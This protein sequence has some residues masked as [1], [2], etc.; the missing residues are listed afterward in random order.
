M[1][2]FARSEPT[3]GQS[4]VCFPNMLNNQGFNNVEL[5]LSPY[6]SKLWL[7]LLLFSWKVD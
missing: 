5:F 1:R 7:F 2:A 4:V 3:A 6:L